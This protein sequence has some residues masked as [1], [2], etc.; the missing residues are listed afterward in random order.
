M[1]VTLIH[2][3]CNDIKLLDQQLLIGSQFFPREWP[4][5][6]G[7]RN[8]FKTG[9]SVFVIFHFLCSHIICFARCYSYVY[10]YYIIYLFFFCILYISIL[11]ELAYQA[12]FADIITIHVESTL[13]TWLRCFR[14]TQNLEY[15]IQSSNQLHSCLE[16]NER[17]ILT[18]WVQVLICAVKDLPKGQSITN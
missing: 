14:F 1:G 18:M 5:G 16:S 11:Y 15:F 9:W 12:C 17:F 13:W 6:E 3:K 10:L 4:K 7:F 8:V 2:P